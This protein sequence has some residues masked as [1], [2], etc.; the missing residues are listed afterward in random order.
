MVY[1]SGETASKMAPNDLLL[2]VMPL[3][4][5][6]PWMWGGLIDWL[7]TNRIQKRWWNAPSEMRLDGMS[8]L[9]WGL[10]LILSWVTCPGGS[11]LPCCE[12]SWW[13][14]P[15]GEEVRWATTVCV[16]ASRSFSSSQAFR[17]DHSLGQH[18]DFNQEAEAPARASKPY[19]DS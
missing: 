14:S 6:S 2:L 13:K 18:P 17:W 16:D 19:S 15:T 5:L 8:L 9:S 11:W 3:G 12:V 4:K 1:P 10:S 7:L